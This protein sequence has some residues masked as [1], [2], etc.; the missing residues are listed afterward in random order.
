MVISMNNLSY[1]LQNTIWLGRLGLMRQLRSWGYPYIPYS[2]VNG[3]SPKHVPS[4]R[5]VS[6]C[7]CWLEATGIFLVNLWLIT[8]VNNGYFFWNNNEYN[9][10]VLTGT[11]FMT[12]HSVG[13]HHP[14][15]RTPSFFRGVGI[16]VGIYFLVGALEHVL[17]FH[18]IWVVILPIN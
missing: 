15:W 18:N 2:M 9:W 16:P 11:C 1:V 7:W 8:M 6:A 14:N 3:V 13:N 17:F 4:I 5:W 10:L 12:F